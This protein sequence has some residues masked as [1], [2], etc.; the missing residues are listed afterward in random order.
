MRAGLEAAQQTPEGQNAVAEFIKNSRNSIADSHRD[1]T[2]TSLLGMA[3]VMDGTYRLDPTR[4]NPTRTDP[5][6]AC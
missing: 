4:N 2:V 3:V 1:K 6:S 5:R